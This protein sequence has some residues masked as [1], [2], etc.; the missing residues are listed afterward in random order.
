MGDLLCQV[1]NPGCIG[2]AKF[3]C[4]HCGKPLCSRCD[5]EMVDT[6]FARPSW[7]KRYPKAHH[8]PDCFHPSGFRTLTKRK[9]VRIHKYLHR[10]RF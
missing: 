4:H 3:I 5:M 9:T 1:R 7:R 10:F 8:C 6:Q 2:T